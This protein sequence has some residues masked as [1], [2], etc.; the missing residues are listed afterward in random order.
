MTH[1]FF[2]DSCKKG[3]M[4]QLR[5]NFYRRVRLFCELRVRHVSRATGISEFAITQIEKHKREP[6]R[7]EARL[8]E[9]FLRDRLRMVF[10]MEGPLPGW[11]NHRAAEHIAGKLLVDC[12]S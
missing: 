12:E 6:D 4:A 7:V 11:G 9:S 8:I 2:G 1:R 3:L 5:S 10:E